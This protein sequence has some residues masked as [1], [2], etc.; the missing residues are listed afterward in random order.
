M[1]SR[2]PIPRTVAASL[3]ARLSPFHLEDNRRVDDL[4]VEPASPRLR[5]AT[6]T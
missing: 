2:N 3:D 5:S 1:S 6:S 4:D